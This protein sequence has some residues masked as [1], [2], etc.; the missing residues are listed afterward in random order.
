MLCFSRLLTKFV[1]KYDD[2]FINMSNFCKIFV[3]TSFN[4]MTGPAVSVFI[5]AFHFMFLT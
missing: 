4:L 5:T 3:N 1:R 2:L